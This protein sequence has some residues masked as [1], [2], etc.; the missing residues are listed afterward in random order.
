LRPWT[1]CVSEQQAIYCSVCNFLNFTA[2]TPSQLFPPFIAL[3]ELARRFALRP[4]SSEQG[5]ETYE[6]IAVEDHM[7]GIIS[8]LCRIPAVREEFMLGDGVCFDN[9]TNALTESQV[10]AGLGQQ[11]ILRRPRP[12]QFCIH[13]VDGNTNSLLLT[14]EYKP[15]HKLSV[16]TLRAGL[17]PMELWQEMVQRKTVPTDPTEKLR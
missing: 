16:E 13:R 9:H 10:E 1:D 4:I 5:V 15:P 2:D 14:V 8:E 3:E 7:R 6:R 17:R 11:P 12:D